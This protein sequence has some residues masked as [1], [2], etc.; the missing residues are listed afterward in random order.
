MNDID[1][2]DS[3]LILSYKLNSENAEM[4]LRR[5]RISK[6]FE[7]LKTWISQ[8]FDKYIEAYSMNFLYIAYES[9][10][11]RLNLI[12]GKKNGT[13]AKH[14]MNFLEKSNEAGRSNLVYFCFNFIELFGK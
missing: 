14:A 1:Y 3:I 7:L 6:Y 11:H 4:I 13:I 10:R 5:V 2:L 9:S 8:N 12:D